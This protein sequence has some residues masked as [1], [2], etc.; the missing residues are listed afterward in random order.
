MPGGAGPS[1]QAGRRQGQGGSHGTCCGVTRVS[2]CAL[3][4]VEHGVYGFEALHPL[5]VSSSFPQPEPSPDPS[6]TEHKKD[7]SQDLWRVW[8]AV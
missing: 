6:C 2:G 7:S 8:V 5:G 3:E 4:T 1:A